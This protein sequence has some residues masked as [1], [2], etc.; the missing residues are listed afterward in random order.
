LSDYIPE[1]GQVDVAILFFSLSAIAPKYHEFVIENVYKVLRP[2]GWLLFRDFCE[3]DLAQTRFSKENQ[4]EEQ[5]FVR[6]DGTFSYF[7]RIGNSGYPSLWL[8]AANHFFHLL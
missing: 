2:G 8:E 5:W 3:G 1:K 4:V 7:F 6:Q